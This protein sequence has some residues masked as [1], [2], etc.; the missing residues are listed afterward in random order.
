MDSTIQQL[1]EYTSGLTFEKLPADVVQTATVR[2]TDAIGCGIGGFDADTVAIARRLATLVT[3]AA[4][5][6]RS[7]FAA[8]ARAIGQSQRTTSIEAAALVNAWMI[9]YLDFNDTYPG[10]HPSD[11]LGPLI[12]LAD[13]IGASGKKLV[14]A[15][16]AA[17]DIFIRQAGAAQLREKG[18][19]QGFGIG[20]GA[21]AGAS[22][23]LDLDLERTANAIALTAV[24]NVPM[25]A[26]RAGNLSMWKGGT[27]GY[28]ARN[29]MFL[30]LLAAEG[31]TGP[32]APIDGRH[33]LKDLVTGPFA[34]KPF[35][36][37][38]DSFITH[39]A[40]LKYWPVENHLQAAVWAGIELREKVPNEADLESVDISSYWAAW[41]ETASEPAKWEPE[42]RETADHSMPYILARAYRAGVIDLQAFERESYTDPAT[43]ALMRKITAH[44]DDDIETRFPEAV[45]MRVQ[46]RSRDG[47]VHDIEI[48]NPRGHQDN[49]VTDD[50]AAEK[51]VRLLEPKYGSQRTK[52]VL[53]AWRNI[54]S[55]DNVADAHDLLNLD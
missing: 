25:R 1:A 19:D 20:L 52:V 41:H 35:T 34:L 49:P 6:D 53:D 31:M 45:V 28:H 9:R 32:E 39:Q 22:I 16:V 5:L 14:T 27:T 24:A 18:W 26:T 55:F 42:T 17:Y 43:R 3:P 33:G 21:A 30:A 44:T 4:G 10:G 48:V 47:A 51:F 37:D 15:L 2:I 23:L 29:A 8:P 38:P 36:D 11:V 12:A 54:Q 46:A 40:W 13:Q 50:E 7:P